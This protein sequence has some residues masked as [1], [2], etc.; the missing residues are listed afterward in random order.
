MN[1]LD[2]LP[3]GELITRGLEDNAAGRVTRESCLV[4]IG[5]P[6]LMRAG[7]DLRSH[8][9]HQIPDPERRLYQLIGK[10]SGDAYS[11]Y[12]AFI[13]QLLSFESALEQQNFRKAS[14]PKFAASS[15]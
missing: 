3:G 6:R 1:A 7:L 9:L 13:R 8:N 10:E 2:H 5:W 12:N 4:A 15:R 14:K 11:C